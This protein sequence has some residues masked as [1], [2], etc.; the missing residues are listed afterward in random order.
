MTEPPCAGCGEAADYYDV[1]LTAWLCDQC[2]DLHYA[3]HPPKEPPMPEVPPSSDASS[4]FGNAAPSANS[5]RPQ[6]PQLLASESR[7][8]LDLRPGVCTCGCGEATKRRFAPGHN[9]PL[10]AWLRR[11]FK[12]ARRV[13]VVQPLG[14]A[15]Y[16]SAAMAAG[17]LGEGWLAKVAPEA[18]LIRT[19]RNTV[20][21]AAI[22][23]FEQWGDL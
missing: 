9:T 19:Y 14:D 15:Q 8:V 22:A 12:Q 5:V 18:E 2:S 20:A 21:E 23:D 17:L 16:V 7:T 3:D 13:L 6:E 1:S 10:I 4:E 11:D